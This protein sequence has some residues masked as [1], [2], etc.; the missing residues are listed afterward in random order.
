[1]VQE[2]LLSPS[3]HTP[4]QYYSRWDNFGIFTSTLCLVHCLITPICLTFLP[5]SL[6]RLVGHSDCTH[7]V[8]AVWVVLFC[9]LG[10]VPRL[11]RKP[12]RAVTLLM[13]L[14]LSL[15]MGCT[16]FE[17]LVETW[18]LEMPLMTAGN[19]LVIAAHWANKKKSCC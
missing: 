3:D 1:M 8:L 5:N 9:C 16:F 12:N 2:I 6:A 4:P 17:R 14:G 19:L 18:Q 7:L 10:I 13:C 11:L 15:V